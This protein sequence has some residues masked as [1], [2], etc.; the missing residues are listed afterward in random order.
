M[1]PAPPLGFLRRHIRDQKSPD[2]N[3]GKRIGEFFSRGLPTLF[4][5]YSEGSID[6]D[7]NAL[8]LDSRLLGGVRREGVTEAAGKLQNLGVIEYSRGQITVSDRPKLEELCCECYAVVR[9]KPIACCPTMRS[10]ET[11]IGDS[12]VS[13]CGPSHYWKNKKAPTVASRGLQIAFCDYRLTFS[14][15]DPMVR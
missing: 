3:H 4:L 7:R 2:T 14:C 10:I 13:R 5:L 9:D 11:A 1:R 12:N 6:R 8:G 15:F